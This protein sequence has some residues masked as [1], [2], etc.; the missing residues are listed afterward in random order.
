MAALIQA[1]AL[2]VTAA[3]GRFTLP[4]PGRPMVAGV[5][6]HAAR[7][8]ALRV[9]LLSN[10]PE[11]VSLESEGPAGWRFVALSGAGVALQIEATAPLT[12]AWGERRPALRLWA[13]EA[14]LPQWREAGPARLAGLPPRALLRLAAGEAALVPL[15]EGFVPARLDTLRGAAPHWQVKGGALVVEATAPSECVIQLRPKSLAK[16]P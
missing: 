13:G 12:R 1:D 2:G 4:L 9:A 15:P 6:L 10:G 14:P 11:V 5:A 3:P 16:S 7:P 8:G